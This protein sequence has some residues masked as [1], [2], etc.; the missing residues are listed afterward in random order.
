MLASP[1]VCRHA[2]ALAMT[3]AM[4]VAAASGCA[5]GDRERNDSGV[6]VVPNLSQNRVDVFVDGKLFTAY[7]FPKSLKKPVLFPLNTAQGTPVTRGFPLAARS[8]ERV[9]HPHHAGLWFNY[10]DV[11]GVDFWNNAVELKPEQQAKMGTIIH[12][13][14][15]RTSNGKNKGELQVVM[16]WLMPGEKTILREETTFIF[17]SA[18]NLRGVDRITKLTAQAE[19]VSLKD[20]KEGTLGMRMTRELEHPSKEPL[21]FTDA[22]GK[23]TAV[24]KLDNTGVTGLYRSSEG[25]TG[26]AVWGTRGRWVTLEG[27]IGSEAVAVAI[28][29]HPRN[30]GYPT[31]WHARGYGLFAANPLGQKALSN[32]KDELNF[33]LEPGQSATFRH[34]ILII[35]GEVTPEKIEAFHRKFV[36]EVK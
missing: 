10:G 30:P 20:N 6:R 23:P 18:A 31:Y 33:A 3:A 16:D 11:N 35:S 25:K 9:D 24:A 32:G 15:K 27:R 28:L 17:H 26:D 5:A 21:V 7:I 8:G 19:R 12:R 2:L 29:D 22:S 13:E 14:V 34:R 36:E 1:S 4:V